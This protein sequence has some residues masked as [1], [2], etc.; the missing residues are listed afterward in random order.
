[1][2]AVGGYLVNPGQVVAIG[3]VK[4]LGNAVDAFGFDVHVKGTQ[5]PAQIGTERHAEQARADLLTAIQ[6]HHFNLG[7][8]SGPE[9]YWDAIDKQH[10]EKSQS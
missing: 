3:P 1:M 7:R 4:K 10:S 5:F 8:S 6:Q 9:E 2:H